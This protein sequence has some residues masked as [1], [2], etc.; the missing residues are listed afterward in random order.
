[1]LVAGLIVLTALLIYAFMYGNFNGF[2][3][4]YLNN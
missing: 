2:N 1:M 3:N 4:S